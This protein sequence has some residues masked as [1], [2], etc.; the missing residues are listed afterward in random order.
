MQIVLA[1]SSILLYNKDEQSSSE[2]KEIFSGI[3]LLMFRKVRMKGA[4]LLYS[5]TM[6]RDIAGGNPVGAR[7]FQDLNEHWV[8]WLRIVAEST[9]IRSWSK[10]KLFLEPKSSDFDWNATPNGT[11]LRDLKLKLLYAH[12]PGIAAIAHTVLLEATWNV[13]FLGLEQSDS[14]NFARLVWLRGAKLDRNN[15]ATGTQISRMR[16]LQAP[17]CIPAEYGSLDRWLYPMWL[18]AHR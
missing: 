11:L 9:W 7:L 4:L 10:S 6:Y 1:S 2:L 8:E 17:I 15:R 3:I 16:D 13:G 18:H 12:T 5:R 14:E